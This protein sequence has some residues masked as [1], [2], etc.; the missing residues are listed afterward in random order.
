MHPCT[1]I[2]FFVPFDTHLKL[3]FS[4]GR[5]P[6]KRREE[7][8]TSG[9]SEESFLEH[10]GLLLSEVCSQIHLLS[11]RAPVLWHHLVRDAGSRQLLKV[12]LDILEDTLN[13]QVLSSDMIQQ[14]LHVDPDVR[15]CPRVVLFEGL[16]IGHGPVTNH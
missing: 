11:E 6:K 8:L 7:V 1:I 9:Q 13:I 10:V 5:A 12:I 3:K 2:I 16:H 15:S 14:V 4:I